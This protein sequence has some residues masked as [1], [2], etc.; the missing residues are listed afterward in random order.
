MYRVLVGNRCRAAFPLSSFRIGENRQRSPAVL[1]RAICTLGQPVSYHHLIVLLLHA[2]VTYFLR[3]E[4]TQYTCFLSIRGLIS[5][6]L[7]SHRFFLGCLMRKRMFDLSLEQFLRRCQMTLYKPK[8]H[9]AR[10][11][12]P[13]PQIFE[14]M[15][16]P[17]YKKQCH[18]S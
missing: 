13:R 16:S 7:Q 1:F 6:C 14:K 10:S 8:N 5:S 18:S 12:H 9:Q 11:G 15:F 3:L 17:D 2:R 4:R